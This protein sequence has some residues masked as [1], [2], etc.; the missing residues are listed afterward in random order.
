LLWKLKRVG[1]VQVNAETNQA[2]YTQT[3][4]KIEENKGYK[5][6]FLLDLKSGESKNLTNSPESEYSAE[7]TNKENTIR[8]M[9]SIDGILQLFERNIESGEETKIS[10]FS[11]NINGFLFSPNNDFII[12]I[13]LVALKII[14]V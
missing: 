13:Q 14:Y 5:D 2:I 12:Y 6:V 9:K 4:Y 3:E 7:W 8:F 10:S 11:A 1:S